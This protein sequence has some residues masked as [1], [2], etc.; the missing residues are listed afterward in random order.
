MSNLFGLILCVCLPC[1]FSQSV[2]QSPVAVNKKECQSLTIN[3]VFKSRYSYQYFESGHFFRQTRQATQWERISGGGRF[4]VS[5]D[6]AQKTFSLEIRDVRVEDTAT[7]YCKARYWD[8]TH[9]DDDYVD[10]TGTA[11]TV[12]AGNF[13]SLVSRSP[14]LQTS[15]AGDTVTLSCEY[16]GIC[17]YTVYWYCQSPGQPLKYML[18]RHTSGEQNKENVAGGR[19]SASLDATAKIGWLMISQTQLSDS[20]VYYYALSR[21]SARTVIH[22]TERAAQKPEHA[23]NYRQSATDHGDCSKIPEHGVITDT[24]L[25]NTEKYFK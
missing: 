24:M 1:Y 23:E 6:K 17:Q 7:Y 12:T 22:S 18:Q 10:G 15:A 5:T 16:S 13:G 9:S 14:P 20:A 21:L 3:C 25:Q 11:L 4:V 8:G 2:T 19:I